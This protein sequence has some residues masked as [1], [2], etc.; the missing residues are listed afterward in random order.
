MIGPNIGGKTGFDP[1][2]HDFGHQLIASVTETY[3]PVVPEAGNT[4]A[5]KNKAQKGS[6]Y[7]FRHSTSEEDFLTKDSAFLPKHLQNF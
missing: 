4:E 2:H 3:R 7:L 5:F 1:I 6:I